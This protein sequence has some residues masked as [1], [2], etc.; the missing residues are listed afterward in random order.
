MNKDTGKSCEFH[1]NPWHNTDECHLKQS[2]VAE[3]KPSESKVGSDFESDPNKGKWIIDVES[4]ATI[5]TTK[6][7]PS[8]LEELEEG[9]H[10]FHS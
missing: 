2:L 5:A 10:L 6:V 8:E 4:S 9:E 1:K 7:Q 3:L